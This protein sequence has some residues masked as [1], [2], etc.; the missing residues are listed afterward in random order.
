MAV[1][2]GQLTQEF[3]SRVTSGSQFD[4]RHSLAALVAD[5]GHPC[6]LCGPTA[7]ALERFDGFRLFPPYHLLTTRLRNVRR[8]GVAI[9]RLHISTCSTARA[10][11]VFPSQRRREP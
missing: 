3:R 8:V 10:W 9:T 1:T 6:W 2:D 7:A 11:T 4:H 5:V